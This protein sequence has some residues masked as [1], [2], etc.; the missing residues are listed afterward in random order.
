MVEILTF[1]VNLCPAEQV[2]EILAVVDGKVAGLAGIDPIGKAYKLKH[3]ANFGISIDRT[4]WGLGIGRAMTEAAI[5]CAKEAGYTQLELDVAEDN[6]TAIA[7]YKSV[8]FVE[9]GRNPQGFN[10]RIDGLK[11]LVLMRL[12]LK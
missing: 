9:Y 8:G 10:S 12:E 3:R 7:L 6:K 4:Y 2:G 11:G 1:Q 5:E